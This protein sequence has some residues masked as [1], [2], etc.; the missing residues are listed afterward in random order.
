MISDD[1]ITKG[2]K[3]PYRLLSSRSEYRLLTRSDNADTRLLKYG[4]KYGLNSKERY[5]KFLEDEAKIKQ[6]KEMLGITY[7]SNNDEVS[8][9]IESLGFPSPDRNTSYFNL[10]K[11]QGVKYEELYKRDERLIEL[12]PRLAYKVEVDIKYEGYIRIQLQEAQKLH[13]YE[14]FEIPEGLDYLNM[15]GVSL[16]AR[17][18]LDKI[19]P[20]TIGEA[21]R[22]TNVHPSDINSLMLH[23][24]KRKNN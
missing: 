14:D 22:I 13:S 11:R 1:L 12:E 16:E 4:Y 6:T 10:L 20:H 23:I 17:E 5:T 18:K 21:S 8:K 7:I 9:Y 2:T 15:D 19:K 3:E 24:K